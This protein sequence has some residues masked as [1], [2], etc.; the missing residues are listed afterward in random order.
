MAVRETEKRLSE[1]DLNNPDMP[2]IAL[3]PLQVYRFAPLAVR[4]LEPE[5]RAFPFVFR[6]GPYGAL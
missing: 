5:L 3:R 2:R 4:L 6:R 1:A